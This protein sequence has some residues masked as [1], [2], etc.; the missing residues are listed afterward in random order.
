[1]F[2]HQ[3]AVQ[4]ITGLLHV[5]IRKAATMTPRFGAYQHH[6]SLWIKVQDDQD[7][8]RLLGRMQMIMAEDGTLKTMALKRVHEKKWEK[9]KRKREEQNIRRANR[10]E[11]GLHV[12]MNN[13]VVMDCSSSVTYQWRAS[14]LS[15]P[16]FD[17]VNLLLHSTLSGATSHILALVA[18]VKVP[19]VQNVL[20]EFGVQRRQLFKRQCTQSLILVFGHTKS[21]TSDVVR[22]TERNAFAHQVLGQVRGQHLFHKEAVHFVTVR[23]NR[24]QHARGY[25]QAVLNSSSSV[26]NGSAESRFSRGS[27]R[28]EPVKPWLE[29]F[30]KFFLLYEY[31][32]N[33]KDTKVCSCHFGRNRLN[34]EDSTDIYGFFSHFVASQKFLPN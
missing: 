4:M 5:G 9:R 21:S 8:V 28:A 6:R 32:L 22:L 25:L 13:A 3:V 14:H 29:P 1:M 24:G 2:T 31:I 7:P 26:E 19:H 33:I 34:S 15:K 17:G 23:G 20:F 11:N 10:R 27:S 16:R 18:A 30:S 12:K